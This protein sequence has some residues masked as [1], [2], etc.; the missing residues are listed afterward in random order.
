MS[1]E[2]L[3]RRGTVWWLRVSRGGKGIRESLRTSDAKTA[4]RLRDKRLA[5]IN[6]ET[7]LASKHL[8]PQQLMSLQILAKQTDFDESNR[9]IQKLWGQIW[10]EIQ[11]SRV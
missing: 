5:Q 1:Q 9:K 7:Y 2:H 4:R 3:Y 6:T 11:K 10:E 8:H